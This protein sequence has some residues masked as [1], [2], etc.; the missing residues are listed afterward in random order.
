MKLLYFCISLIVG[1]TFLIPNSQIFA[2]QDAQIL[3]EYCPDMGFYI[4]GARYDGITN[5]LYLYVVN[6]GKVDLNLTMTF[7]YLDGSIEKNST[8]VEIE[9]GM[10][11]VM[12][13]HNVD[14]TL[15]EVTIQSDQ[16]P[17]LQDLIQ[18]SAIR[19]LDF[20]LT[21]NDCQTMIAC[22]LIVGGGMPQC[23]IDYTP[24]TFSVTDN[25]I[26]EQDGKPVIRMLSTTWCPHCNWIKSTFDKVVKEYADSGKIVAYH[27]QL[28]SE[29]N[30]L[31]DGIE[32]KVPKS[33]IEIFNQFNPRNSVPTFI[34][35]CKYYRIGNGYEEN[36]DLASEEREFM[37]II[38][39]LINKK[40]Y[41]YCG[42][43]C[44]DGF[45]D[46]YEKS[47]NTCPEDC[48]YSLIP[49]C[50][51]YG[52]VEIN[53]KP[54]F[55]GTLIIAKMNGEKRGSITTIEK[56]RY[57]GTKPFEPNLIVSGNSTD[58]GKT[59]EFYIDNNKAVQTAIWHSGSIRELNLSISLT[60]PQPP[61]GPSEGDGGNYTLGTA[62]GFQGFQ[63]HSGGWE[64]NTDGELRLTIKNMVGSK[65]KIKQI[66]ATFENFV[67]LRGP[68]NTWPILNPNEQYTFT[69]SGLDKPEEGSSYSVS[70]VIT[71]DNLDTGITG[72]KSFGTLTGTVSG[73]RPVLPKPCTENWVCMQ[74]GSC[75]NNQQT[76]VCT[77]QNYCGTTYNKPPEKRSCTQ[78]TKDN[79]KLLKVIMGLEQT[80][81]ILDSLKS[82]SENLAGY[83]KTKVGITKSENWKT[84]SNMF[85]NAIEMINEIEN[86][87][88]E[89]KS[90]EGTKEKISNLK[91]YINTITEKILEI[92]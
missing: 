70:V 48:G 50:S 34:F 32:S 39:I 76:R 58:E 88:K 22:P 84:V 31:T 77:D 62:T 19:G 53:G 61:S 47:S 86:R 63:I 25:D 37:N 68:F 51:F 72:Y 16:C 56:G 75:I 4:H 43:E 27:W 82:V 24:P 3:L 12:V 14:D 10:F 44:G 21:D 36:N 69:I 73:E 17:G 15:E 40:G 65:I 81:P 87:I 60:P 59:I 74:W 29:D 20:C 80:K 54:A 78:S 55:P 35:G 66:Q 38:E 64:L 85:G 91:S 30:T 33:E 6:T 18:R 28:D 90:L 89:T 8:I 9:A 42:G 7:L 45:C 92:I 2:Q 83:Y 13:Q 57:G 41:C 11:G 67:V 5:I 52:N 23:S 49:P 26:C 46:S 1:I 79:E 71:Y